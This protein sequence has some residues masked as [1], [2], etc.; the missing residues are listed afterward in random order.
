MWFGHGTAPHNDE[1]DASVAGTSLAQRI[2]AL[3]YG[4]MASLPAA[5]RRQAEAQYQ[6][7]LLPRLTEAMTAWA[8]GAKLDRATFAD[9]FFG[10][11]AGD[12]V[13]Q[14]LHG[15]A[16][17]VGSAT[18]QAEMR[19]AAGQVADAMQTVGLNNW[20]RFVADALARAGHYVVCGPA[21]AAPVPRTDDTPVPFVDDKGAVVLKPDGKPMMRP[22]D[23]RM[24][25]HFFVNQGLKDK[26]DEEMLLETGGEER[27][28]SALGYWIGALC[29]FD[30]WHPW[31]AQRINHT[32]HPEFV[33][34]ATVAIGLYAAANGIPEKDIL[35]IENYAARDSHFDPQVKMDTTYTHLPTRNIENTD[36]GYWLYQHGRIAATPEP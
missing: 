31:D 4:A 8:H 30:R 2:P 11:G 16:V 36:R 6:N 12:P 17:A 23:A 24:D 32:Y 7:G 10:R 34:Y 33:D 19:H 29:H 14:K 18:S 15:A 13:V 21:A 20:P 1:T 27:G 9:R 28:L 25:P 3:A 5:Q 22:A 26:K 35:T